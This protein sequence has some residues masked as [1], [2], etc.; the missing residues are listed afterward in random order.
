[1]ILSCSLP[2]PAGSH[3][4]DAVTAEELFGIEESKTFLPDAC[5]RRGDAATAGGVHGAR[6]VDGRDELLA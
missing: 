2:V 3:C 5:G 4:E 6:R 1:M